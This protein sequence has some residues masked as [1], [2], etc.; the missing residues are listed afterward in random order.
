MNIVRRYARAAGLSLALAQA[1]CSD[2]SAPSPTPSSQPSA[3][4]VKVKNLL[5]GLAA[6]QAEVAA[7]SADASALAD[8]IDGWMETPEFRGKLLEFFKHAFQQ[9]QLNIAQ[10]DDLLGNKTQYMPAHVK[11]AIVRSAEESFPR[12]VL[13]LIDEGRPF[14]EVLT[15]ERFMLNPPLMSLLA[16][17]DN[18]VIDD[19]GRSS[20]WLQEKFADKFVYT[21]HYDDSVQ[22]PFEASIDPA[23]PNFLHFYEP[24]P[25]KNG[26]ISCSVTT[27]DRPDRVPQMIWDVIF[28]RDVQAASGGRSAAGVMM[29][30]SS[31]TPEFS[32]ADWSD[33]RM[34]Q[35]RQPNSGEDPSIFWELPAFRSREP[36]ARVLRLHTP[37]V[38]F[39]TTPAFFA[40]WPTN[41]SNLARATVNQTLIVSLGYSL[42]DANAVV[43]VS[44]T[45]NPDGEHSQ[46]GTACFACHQTLDPLRNFFRQSFSVSYHV[47]TSPLPPEQQQAKFRLDE[48]DFAGTGVRDLA[49]AIAQHSRFAPAWT[50]KLCEFANSSPC[51]VDDPEFQRVSQAFRDSDYDFKRLIRELFSSTLVTGADDMTIARR[52]HLCAALQNRLGPPDVC[53]LSAVEASALQNLAF[54]IPG[55]GYT[56]GSTSALLPRESN[57]FSSSSLEGLCGLVARRVIDPETCGPAQQFFSSGDVPSAIEAMVQRIMALPAGD[58]RS[59][60]AAQILQAH[61]E[62]AT[63]AGYSA[64]EALQSTFVLACTSPTSSAI[65]F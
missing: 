63:G 33:W 48:V 11:A 60:D 65:G 21:L 40:N 6:N 4:A 45:G 38:G 15:T 49:A 32:D 22:L 29:S 61:F 2:S 42:A 5:T 43:P 20:S 54:G 35:I 55:A 17:I 53:D 25:L 52:D 14:H 56:R 27:I 31:G 58:A 3:A 41:L 28:G 9:T 1:A 39:M 26:Q 8:L 13:Q 34:I 36:E 19:E 44:E 30:R 37:R 62:A 47:Q 10:F 46:P 18:V 12:T 16:Y 24:C 23:S 59:S 57:L 64:T 51:P 50:Q 7:V